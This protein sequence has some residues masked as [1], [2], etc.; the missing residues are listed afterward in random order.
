MRR[1][2]EYSNSTDFSRYVFKH[3]R[4]L[5][6]P[7][8]PMGVVFGLIL[9]FLGAAFLL[10]NLN[11][12]YIEDALLFWPCALIAIGVVRLWNR[13]FFNVWGQI[14]VVCGVLLQIDYLGTVT[15]I[16]LCWPGMVVWIGLL[17][18]VKAFLPS[19]KHLEV[20]EIPPGEHQWPQPGDIDAPAITIEHENEEQSQ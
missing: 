4:H 19:R 15:A 14:L 17:I 8:L 9:I 11:L 5:K 12:I 10:N 13:G 16:D 20:K 3:K 1:R 6:R 2:D 7:R 18:A